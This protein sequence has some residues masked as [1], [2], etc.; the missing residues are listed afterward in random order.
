[1]NWKTDENGYIVLKDGNPVYVDSNGDEKTVAIDTISRLNNE[2]KTHRIAKE[3]ALEKLKL[4]EGIDA[5]KARMALETVSKL[6]ASKLIESG[7]LEELKSQ[8]TGQFQSQIN[9]KDKAFNDLQTRYDTMVINNVF[10]NSDFIR[11]NVAVPRDMF[12]AKFRAN[13]KVE[14]GE[15]VVYGNDGNRLYSKERAGEYATPEEGLRILAESHPNKDVILRANVSSGSGI[16]GNSGSGGIGRYMKRYDFEKLPPIKQA[17]YAA[18]I[19]A[20]E[21]KLTD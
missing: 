3:E 12:E 1:M 7:K 18:K 5:E 2:A 17:E 10:A 20:G 4:F 21:I 13:F 11:D 19:R 14:N 6:D 16:A 9:E 8:I 15:V